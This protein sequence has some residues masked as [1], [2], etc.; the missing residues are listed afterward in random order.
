MPSCQHHPSVAAHRIWPTARAVSELEATIRTKGR[1]ILLVSQKAATTG[2]WANAAAHAFDRQVREIASLCQ[3]ALGAN[4]LME[5]SIS[6]SILPVFCRYQNSA[7]CRLEGVGINARKMGHDGGALRDV[8][9]LRTG[10]RKDDC[11]SRP[12]R[13]TLTMLL[14]CWGVGDWLAAT[15][16]SSPVESVSPAP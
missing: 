15:G 16:T 9:G 13:Q 3:F 4:P 5:L 10:P 11:P 12:V 1:G 8:R 2:T 14:P 6:S 7:A